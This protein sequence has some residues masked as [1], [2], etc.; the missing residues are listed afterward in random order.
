[1]WENTWTSASSLKSKVTTYLRT[2][3]LTRWWISNTVIMVDSL[4]LLI[5]TYLWI[6]V[7]TQPRLVLV[8]K[9]NK[10]CLLLM[11]S[12]LNIEYRII[13]ILTQITVT[14]LSAL[15]AS[16]P[17]I[18][19]SALTQAYSHLNQ[20]TNEDQLVSLINF[21]NWLQKKMNMMK[22]LSIILIRLNT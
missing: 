20:F 11:P 10:G 15:A 19:P 17:A 6:L 9:V 5:L 8:K 4:T 1:M 3:L 7:S 21:N 16:S 14:R 12:N 22:K 13:E 2:V 18:S